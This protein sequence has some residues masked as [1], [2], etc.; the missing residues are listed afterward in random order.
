MKKSVLIVCMLL[1]FALTGC[2]QTAGTEAQPNPAGSVPKTTYDSPAPAE[3]DVLD[4]ATSADASTEI[5]APNTTNDETQA[6]D[7]ILKAFSFDVS[8][9]SPEITEGGKTIKYA[10]KDNDR[11]FVQFGDDLPY[12]KTVYHFCH[13]KENNDFDLSEESDT[14]YDAALTDTAKEFVQNLY[15]VDCTDADVHAF[16]YQDKIAIQLEVSPDVIFS[17]RFYYKDEDPVG[18]LFTD[19]IEL[20]EKA[21]ETNHAKQYF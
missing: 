6:R 3:A 17:V 10:I 14:Y 13:Y 15:G 18:V 16:G 4:T 7:L 11:Y 9:C 8:D 12:P 1:S 5:T 19:E 21:M 20:C 2:A